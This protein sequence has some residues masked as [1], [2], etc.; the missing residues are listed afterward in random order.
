M[1]ADAAQI[2]RLEADLRQLQVLR[3]ADQ[4]E[5]AGLR[6]RATTLEGG[7]AE[8]RDQQTATAEILRIIASSPTQLQQ[9][10]DAIVET[11]ARLCEAPSATL[12]QLR[13]PEG[14]L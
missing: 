9:A 4:V 6:Q 13:E 5:V 11:A 10:L 2:E 14:L 8:A 7:L 12:H 1:P 3:A